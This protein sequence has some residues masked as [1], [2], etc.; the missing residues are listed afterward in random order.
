M[1]ATIDRQEF[2]KVLDVVLAGFDAEKWHLDED[3]G[4]IRVWSGRNCDGPHTGDPTAWTALVAQD[5]PNVML[6]A[7]RATPLAACASHVEAFVP[8]HNVGLAA[9]HTACILRVWWG[10]ALPADWMHG[11]RIRRV[12]PAT[13]MQHDA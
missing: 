13:D 7:E 1:T 5:G 6:T 4:L 12:V 2:A 11:M 3:G 9:W 8:A 10:M